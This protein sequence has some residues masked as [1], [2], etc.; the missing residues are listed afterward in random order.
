MKN[1]YQVGTHSRGVSQVEKDFTDERA[2][3]IFKGQLEAEGWYTFLQIKMPFTKEEFLRAS[4]VWQDYEGTKSTEAD[5]KHYEK[6]VDI[7]DDPDN[8][9]PEQWAELEKWKARYP[10]GY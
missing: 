5:I 9:T 2:A 7:V 10:F 8:F 3:H 6:I 1:I 4:L